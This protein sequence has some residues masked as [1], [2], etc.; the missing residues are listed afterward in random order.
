MTQPEIKG[1]QHEQACPQNDGWRQFGQG[2]HAQTHVR[3][4][5]QQCRQDHERILGMTIEQQRRDQRV[6]EASQRATR[7]NQQIKAGQF[8]RSRA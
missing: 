3:Q 8:R 5:Q 4:R 6:E 2:K 1:E 7:G